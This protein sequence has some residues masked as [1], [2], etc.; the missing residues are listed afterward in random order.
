MTADILDL[1]IIVLIVLSAIIGLV[2]GFVREAF[3]LATWLAALAFA[4]LYY[5]DLAVH[6]PF[7]GQGKLGQV[8]IAGI[9]IFLG[10]LIIGSIINHL[11]SAAISSVGLGGVDYLLGGAFGILRG[12]LIVTLL[13][14]LFGAVGNVSTEAWWQDSR[15][16]PWFEETAAVLKEM[17]PNKLPEDL[18]GIFSS[19]P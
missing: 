8:I 17:I 1:S 9:V 19:K 16:M 4:F 6:V 13:V 7:T 15:L 11:L 14:L 10:V 12:G 2:R 18:S 3:S 5:K